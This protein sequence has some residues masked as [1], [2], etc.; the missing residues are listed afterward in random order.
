MENILISSS[1]YKSFIYL[2]A[3]SMCVSVFWFFLSVKFVPPVPSISSFILFFPDLWFSLLFFCSLNSSWFMAC[4]N[5]S[6][7]DWIYFRTEQS[8]YMSDTRQAFVWLEELL[9]SMTLT[10]K[11]FVFIC[12]FMCGYFFSL[13][14]RWHLNFQ[15][16]FISRLKCCD[17]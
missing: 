3:I 8:L 6:A 12:M 1:L 13:L 15:F 14:F 5:C 7:E 9:F 4:V 2:K 16:V 17:C 11:S 10:V